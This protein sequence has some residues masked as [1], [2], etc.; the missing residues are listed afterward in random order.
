MDVKKVKGKAIIGIAMAAIMLASV[1]V[2]TVLMVSAE[3]RGDNFNHIVVQPEP[4]KVLIGQNLQFDGFADM[5]VVYRLVGGDI[6]NTYLADADNRIYNVN[7]PTSGSY[8]VN[9]VDTTTYDAQLSVEDA[10]IPLKLKVGTRDV[11]SIAVNTY[12][13]IDTAG[14]NLFP[15][16]IV[17]LKIIGPDGQIKYDETNNQKFTRISVAQLNEWYGGSPNEL[18]T[19][20]WSIG[21]YTFQV[22]TKSNYACGLDAASAVKGLEVI[23]GAIAIE[24]DTTSCIELET[25]ELTVTGVAGDEIRVEGDCPNVVFQPSIDDTPLSAKDH[26]S[27][28][29]DAIDADMVRKYAVEF[30]DTGIYTITV[31]VTGPIWNPRVGDYDTVDIAVSE[32]VVIFDV[33][34]TV[35]IGENFTIRGTA[36][37]GDTVDIAVGDY[38]YPLL[39]DLII[40]E[41][42]EFRKEIDTA[43]AGIAPFTD[44]GPVR[45]TAY[46]ERAAGV[47]PVFW[48]GDGSEK[49][50]ML[51]AAGGGIDISTSESNV[52]KNETI[53]L[54]IE[55]LPDHNVSVTTADP[56]HRVFEYNRYDFTGTSNNIINIAPADTIS[57]LADIGD[58]DSQDDAMNIHGVWKTMD[59]DG[60]RKFEVHFTDTGTYKITATDYGTD[61]PN[62]TRLDEEDIEITVSAKNV[63]FDVPSIVVIGDKITIRGTATSGTYVDIFADDK[64]YSKLDDIVIED[65]EFSKEVI[66]TEVGLYVPGIA[67]LRAYIDCPFPSVAGSLPP[68]V[69]DGST[70]VFMVEPWLTASLSMDSVDQED[71]FTVSG[72]APGSREVV[73]LSVP[74]KGGGGKSLLDKGVKGVALTK[75]SVSTTDNAFSKKFWVQ[76]DADSGVYYVIVLSPGMDGEWDMTGTSNLETA[77]DLRYRIPSLTSGIINTKTP[78][79][80]VEIFE[81]L[82]QCAGSDDLMRILTIKVGKIET[83]T[84]NPMADVV[85][86]NPLK[87][88]GETSREDGSIIWITVKGR[89]QEIA[90]Q[91]AIVKNNTFS[92]TF[93]TTG[94]QPGTYA[95][96]A[97]DEYGYTAATTMDIIAETPA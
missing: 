53:I 65:G 5:P 48:R 78:D 82:T 79:Q 97:I 29:N 43:T 40:D 4:Q 14:M 54:A 37:T 46:I 76:E 55:A 34:S 51:N 58:C 13:R 7:W 70:N 89:Y 39:N 26:P 74:P 1:L 77:L 63:T 90:T 84:L 23:I 57:I 75:A 81:D 66:T 86:G 91:A 68:T 24:A 27:W 49:I 2:A 95:V 45:L 96:K 59:G 80:I 83:L 94:A 93:D 25:V 92:V 20:G 28:F 60:I 32:K 6:V 12:L 8:Y 21:D 71:E 33:P 50:F 42:G 38:V 85:V 72:S 67:E 3:S 9:Y 64:L 17:D 15:E 31:T 18:A 87:V 88:T 62:A 16:D 69:D 11:S 47:G 41:D 10:H 73:I 30:N 61:Y 22:K 35:I 56:A 44:S 52:G 19:K 36:N